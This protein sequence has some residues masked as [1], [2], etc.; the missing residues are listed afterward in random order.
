MRSRWTCW[1]LLLPL[2]L[3]AV[4]AARADGLWEVYQL[5]RANDPQLKA[6]EEALLAARQGRPK[7]LASLLPSLVASGSSGLNHFEDKNPPVDP[8]TGAARP[9]QDYDSQRYG[10]F[11]T[12][13][14]VNLQ[15][16]V[17]LPQAGQRQ[18]EAE[19]NYRASLGE[20]NLRLLER[21]LRVLGNQERLDLA[22]AEKEA[23]AQGLR[24]ARRASELGLIPPTAEQR[25]QA[26]YDLAAAD[27]I[28]A[29][30]RL[31]NSRE[32]LR[33][34]TGAW[35]QDLAPLNPQLEPAPPEPNDLA[36]WQNLALIANHGLL[37][38]EHSLAVARLEVTRQQAGHA[39]VLNLT[40]SHYYENTGGRVPGEDLVSSVALEM[41]IPLFEGGGVAA[42]TS[43]ARHLHDKERQEYER[44][45]RQTIKRT[46]EAFRGVNESLRRI[47]A[48]R[49]ALGSNQAS[50][51]SAQHE[52]AV[53]ASTMVEFLEA[54][55]DL[56]RVR[57]DLTEARHEYLLQRA[58]LLHQAGALGQDHIETVSRLFQDDA[59]AAGGASPAPTLGAAAPGPEPLTLRYQAPMTEPAK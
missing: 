43:E 44:L 14:V 59:P 58:R 22:R 52:V 12:Q 54:L 38:K 16:W 35:H 32:E 10:L 26:G 11:L 19:A 45:R 51:E 18:E 41:K 2:L 23:I 25:A 55:R 29:E 30:D 47:R 15:H 5:A 50:V 53:G 34:L 46:S 7:A 8:N 56:Y 48:L 9:N 21:Y 24:R 57:R 36:R 40:A 33:E 20:F 3:G 42:Q 49:R 17:G 1:G 27:E 6:A 39:P 37:A 13:P 4:P 31:E 28:A